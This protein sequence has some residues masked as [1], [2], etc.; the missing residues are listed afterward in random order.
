MKWVA[1]S[2]SW[3]KINGKVEDDVRREVKEVLDRGDGI[4]SGGALNVDY[5][6]TDEALK[7]DPSGGR[8]KIFIPATLDIYAA[9]YRQRAEQG[10]ITKQQA[11]DLIAQLRK[12]K[13]LK[14]VPLV[15]NPVNKVVDRKAYFERNSAVINAA[16]ELVAFHVNKSEGV[17]NTI[18]K[19]KRKG[20]PIKIFTYTI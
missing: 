1:I 3:Q 19:A 4:V 8:V 2:G 12:L 18:V 14:T 20:I 16:D 9:H 15:E 6:A 13:A 7:Y 11:E 17:I 5:L 10:I